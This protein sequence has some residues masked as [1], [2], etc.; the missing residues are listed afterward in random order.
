MKVKIKYE[1]DVSGLPHCACF[2]KA[3]TPEG[4]PLVFRGRST[5]AEAR[6]SVLEALRV[7][8]VEIPLVEEVEL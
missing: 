6:E 4:A 2:A 8:P 1:W 5:F 3:Y 7:T